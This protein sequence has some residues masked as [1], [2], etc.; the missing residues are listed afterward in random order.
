MSRNAT[1]IPLC[2]GALVLAVVGLSAVAGC[3]GSAGQS[4]AGDA[5]H[6]ARGADSA[7]GAVFAEAASPPTPSVPP[8][9]Y[10]SPVEHAIRV[11]GTFGELRADHFHHGLDIKSARGVAGDPLHVVAVGHVSRLLVSGRG[12]GNAVYVDHPDGSRTLYAH[13][14]AFAPRLQRVL[15]SIHYARE[16]FELDLADLPPTLLPVRAGEVIGTMGNTGSSRGVHLHFEVRD[17]RTDDAINPLL[18]AGIP[19]R[20]TRAPEL[21]HLRVYRDDG[22]GRAPAV[23]PLTPALLGDP[24]GGYLLRDT[25][26]VPPGRI[27]FAVKA[28]DRQ[29]GTRNLNGVYRLHAEVDGAPLFASTYDTIAFAD[30]RY[31]QAHY[32]YA[33]RSGG[34]GYYYRLFRLPGD[35]LPLYAHGPDAGLLVLRSGESRDIELTASDPLG[36]ASTLRFVVAAAERDAGASSAA[37]APSEDEGYHLMLRVREPA[38]FRV[39][40]VEAELPAGA[41]YADTPL[42]YS[43]DEAADPLARCYR[44]G[45]PAEPLHRPLRVRVDLHGLPV[46]LRSKAYLGACDDVELV[47]AGELTTGS[48]HLE[49]SLEA[50]GDF[51]LRI[52]TVPPTIR[53]V[54][55]YTYVLEDDVWSDTA[56]RYRVT[57]DGRW[58]LAAYDAKR[59]R[60]ELRRDRLRG[61]LIEV[62]AWD[63]VGNRALTRR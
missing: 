23:L 38:S 22:S 10:R 19:V 13:L 5:V 61:G 25:L 26:R 29:E 31:I 28:Y 46:E 40:A 47:A 60:L 16:S 51:R 53:R 44:L 33:A 8:L 9:T 35:R 15:D 49:A 37:L 32:D 3:G 43:V 14:D 7:A 54:D 21:R 20:D 11:S 1:R 12:Y 27:G 24:A 6:A 17:A 58:V 42:R 59:G 39:G 56:L 52:D 34:E 57:E 18:R 4:P 50:W 36:N 30:T 41:V 55:D 48:S 2:S 63:G 62:T 45:D